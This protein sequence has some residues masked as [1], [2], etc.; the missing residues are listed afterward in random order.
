[1]NL[2]ADRKLV[3]I[4]Y[5]DLRA[6]DRPVIERDGARLEVI[7]GNVAGTSGPALNHW[8]ISGTL[9]TLEPDRHIDHLLPGADRRGSS[10]S[11]P[12]R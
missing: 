5:Q 10:R 1:M 11:C 2:P 6:A 12:V 8:P 4:R 9:I 3:V 7:S